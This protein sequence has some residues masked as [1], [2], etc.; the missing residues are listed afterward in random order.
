MKDED[1][2]REE[3]LRE[4]SELRQKLHEM[5]AMVAEKGEAEE[6]YRTLVESSYASVYVVQGGM[7]QFVNPR[8][9]E[10]TGY[11]EGEMLGM[12]SV[13]LIHP[14][15]RRIARQNA[16]RMLKG[17][18]IT[19]YEFRIIN[20]DGSVRWILETVRSIRYKGERAVLGNSMEITARREAREKLEE[21][22]AL[23][24]SILD[25][26]PVALM[27][28]RE[29]R[30]IFANRATETVFGWKPW[31]LVGKSTRVLYRNDEEYEEIG[32]HFYS[33]LEKQRTHS[34][35]FPCRHKDGRDMI[36]LVSTSIIGGSLQEKGIVATYEDISE[37]K[38]AEEALKESE[39]RLRE[40][41]D[42]F[43]KQQP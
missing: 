29:R 28:M 9:A 17:D 25:A 24:S 22:Q 33:V 4:L 34:E 39:E 36:C 14:D 43:W 42:R 6:L 21:L 7:F 12:E 18:R 1:K 23:Q 15:D 41:L 37:H 10:D 30:I 31:E 2:T 11:T 5:A 20:K 3:L 27:G 16:I 13:M 8:F 32:T 35:E 38:K 26:L 40:I 19:P